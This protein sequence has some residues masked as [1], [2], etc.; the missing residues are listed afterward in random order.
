ML[1]NEQVIDG[2]CERCGAEVTK[3]ELTQ[4]YFKITDYAQ[5][6]LDNLDALGPTWPDRVINAQR[7]GSAAPRARTSPSTSSAASR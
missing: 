4:W 3:R 1:A 2:H 7:T 6:L 5:E